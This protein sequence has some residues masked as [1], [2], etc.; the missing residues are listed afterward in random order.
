MILV[1][2]LY[3]FA[4]TLEDDGDGYY[5]YKKIIIDLIYSLIEKVGGNK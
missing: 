1:D 5:G 3:S 2:K 4:D